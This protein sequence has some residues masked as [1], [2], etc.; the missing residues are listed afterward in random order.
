MGIIMASVIYLREP[1]FLFDI[2]VQEEFNGGAVD[3]AFV[4]MYRFHLQREGNPSSEYVR[5]QILGPHEASHTLSTSITHRVVPLMIS[6]N[7]GA[8]HY[9]CLRIDEQLSL[10]WRQASSSED[11][12]RDRLDQ[13]LDELGFY[14]APRVSPHGVTSPP[15]EQL[16]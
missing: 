10:E 14:V 9:E 11:D 7:Q 12:V 2:G 5:I 13:A 8:K 15:R 4:T 16:L 6:F 3:A 1:V